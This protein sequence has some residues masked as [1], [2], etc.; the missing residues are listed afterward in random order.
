[1]SVVQEHGTAFWKFYMS[2]MCFLLWVPFDILGD[3]LH[4]IDVWYPMIGSALLD[5]IPLYVLLN[6]R[7][8]RTSHIEDAGT[9]QT[10][11]FK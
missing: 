3:Y 8:S 7:G 11:C 6:L 4:L 10:V 2:M 1:M 5:G 9:P